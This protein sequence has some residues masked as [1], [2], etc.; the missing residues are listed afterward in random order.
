MKPKPIFTLAA[1]LVFLFGL[2]LFASAQQKATEAKSP[3][4]KFAREAAIGSLFEVQAGELAVKK[5]SDPEVKDFG[6]RMINA[7]SKATQELKTLAASKNIDLPRTLDQEHRE[8]L[9]ELAKTSGAEF[10]NKYMEMMVKDHKKDLSKFQKEAREGKDPDL[11]TWASQQVPILQDH[12][13]VAQN[14]KSDVKA[15]ASG[16]E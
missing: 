15:G 10:D 14:T 7:H 2:A 3:D 4:D 1:A 16:Q 6:Q 13:Q 11:K 8:K 5:A 9:D 12:L